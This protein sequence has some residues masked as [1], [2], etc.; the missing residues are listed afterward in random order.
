MVKGEL[1]LS[2]HKLL[3]VIPTTINQQRAT[4]NH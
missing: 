2:R 3:T 4:I 1:D